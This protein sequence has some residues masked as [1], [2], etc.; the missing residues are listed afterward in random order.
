MLPRSLYFNENS[1]MAEAQSSAVMFQNPGGC[2]TEK[3]IVFVADAS[4]DMV[5]AIDR[6]AS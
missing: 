4:S 6:G 2:G 5:R 1:V 3:N